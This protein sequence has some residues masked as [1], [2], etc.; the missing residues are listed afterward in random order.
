MTKKS[1]GVAALVVSS[2]VGH[3]LY[4]L[5]LLLL[6]RRRARATPPPVPSPLPSVTVLVPAYLEAGVIAQKIANLEANG[7]GGELDVLVVADG[8]AETARVAEGAGARVLLLEQ[9]HGK[10][11]ALNRG[12]EAARHELVVISDA[13]SWLE[14]GAIEALVRWFA[15]PRVGAVAGEKLEDEAGREGVYWRFESLLKRREADLGTTLGLDG[16]LCAVRRSTWQLIPT[17]ISNDDLWIALDLMERGHG[18]AYEPAALVREESVGSL[19]L[20]WERRT[21]VL[22]GGLWVLW[23]KRHLLAPSRGIVAY[24]L[25]GHKLWRSTLGPLSHLALVV[26]A[27]QSL[28]HSRVARFFAIGHALAVGGLAWSANGR[29]LPRLFSVPSQ[30]LFLQLVALGGMRRFL[31]G[32]RVLKWS[33]PA[34]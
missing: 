21:R 28:R 24:E 3:V 6:T 34:R 2:S 1:A 33:K 22:G 31:R 32:D 25:I 7:Y 19:A 15:E 11:Q 30:L 16:G 26:L 10:S 12:M 18:V 27:A 4:P 13:N 8:D 23:R 17:D 5:T 20:Q 9:R 29:S 14:P